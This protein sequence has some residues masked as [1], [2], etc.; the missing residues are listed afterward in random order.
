MDHIVL[1][2]MCVSPV[3][4]SYSSGQV[5]DSCENLKPQHSGLSPQTGPTPFQITTDHSSYGLGEK[6]KVHLLAPASKPFI[7]FLLQARAV[8]TW[9]LLGSFILTGATAQHLPCN[10]RPNSSVSHRSAAP[11]TSVGVMW[12]LEAIADAKPIQFHAT[13]VQNY[14]TFWVNVTSRTLAFTNDSTG[15]PTTSI[16]VTTSDPTVPSKTELHH[17]ASP[18]I[19]ISRDDCGLTKVCFSQPPNCDPAANTD[20]YFMSAQVFPRNEGV[21][22][23]MTGTSNGYIAFGFSDD[24]AMGNDDIYICGVGSHGLVQVQHAFSTGRTPPQALP[25]GNISDVKTSVQDKVIS[26]SFTSSNS[27]ST[28][29]T[30][31]LDEAYHLLFAHG[32]SSNGKIQYH[33]ATFTSTSKVDI[34]RPQLVRTARLPHIIKA[35]GALMLTAWMTSGTLG[36]MVARY[37]KGMATRQSLWGKSIWFLVHVAVIGVTVAATVIGFILAFSHVKAWSGGAHPVLGCLVMILSVLQLM[38]GLL[39]CGPQHP[40][41]FVFN[42]SHA[43]NGTIIKGLS[44]AA[45][46]TG[47][48]LIDS[49]PD[50]WLMKVMGGFFGWEAIFFISLDI[51]LK[52][53][54]NNED[55]LGSKMTTIIILL[56]VLFF[57]GNIIF[58]V[59]LLVGIA[60]S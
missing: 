21:H 36:M 33:T 57:V 44:V 34:S 12:K 11:K 5:T 22:F 4:R 53:K 18:A 6:V 39:R 54:I 41:R 56:T 50:Q 7:G 17:P 43:L 58:L 55:N 28:K 40:K 60:I 42:W 48:K 35:H 46:F 25:L 31:G 37:L 45:I 23:E 38:L 13:F 52:W 59:A 32:P 16:K 49:T 24:Q 3:V 20:C 15:P 30:T 26:C 27:I 10:Q 2:L 8:G 29:R 9:S 19:R 51:H 47:L 1:L 14:R